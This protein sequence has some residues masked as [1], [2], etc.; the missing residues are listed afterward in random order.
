MRLSR[1]ANFLGL[2]FQRLVFKARSLLGC[3]RP[4]IEVMSDK[5]LGMKD[6]RDREGTEAGI[7]AFEGGQQIGGSRVPVP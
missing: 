1:G 5:G 3:E 6:G 7:Q 4:G 2:P